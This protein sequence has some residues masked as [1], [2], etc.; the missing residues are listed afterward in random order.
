MINL[1]DCIH[2]FDNKIQFNSIEKPILARTNINEKRE[3]VHMRQNVILNRDQNFA[4]YH[5]C[6]ASLHDRMSKDGFWTRGSTLWLM[7]IM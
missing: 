5:Q 4:T 3:V 1:L 2:S 6:R 7:N